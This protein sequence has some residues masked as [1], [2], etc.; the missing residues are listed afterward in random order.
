MNF[1]IRVKA[2]RR[3]LSFI[4][5]KGSQIEI[6]NF[7]IYFF[8][9]DCFYLNSVEPDEMPHHASSGLHCLSKYPFRGSRIQRVKVQ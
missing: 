1:L 5:C 2:I 3:G 4:N 8:V 9:G 7:M 6:Y